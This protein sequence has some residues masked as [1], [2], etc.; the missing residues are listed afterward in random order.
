MDRQ[1]AAEE[2]AL[3]ELQAVEHGGHGIT[4]EDVTQALVTMSVA[5]ITS[6][7]NERTVRNQGESK[8]VRPGGKK[9]STKLRFNDKLTRRKPVTGN[10]QKLQS[11]T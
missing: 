8:A 6:G 4:D 2:K 3:Q 11:L 5:D 10:L 7:Q 9:S 1:R